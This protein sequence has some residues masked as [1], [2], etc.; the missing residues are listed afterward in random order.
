ANG[1]I[2]W[3]DLVTNTDHQMIDTFQ[4]DS[5]IL[6]LSLENDNEAAQTVDLSSL[7]DNLGDHTS[8]QNIATNGFYISN[9]GEEEGIFVDTT[10]RVGIGTNSPTD[11]LEVP[12][13][14][15]DGSPQRIISNLAEDEVE[16]IEVAWQSYTATINGTLGTISIPS[17]GFTSTFWTVTIYEGEGITGTV[18]GSLSASTNY[19]FSSLNIEQ[20]AN[21]I[22]TFSI[23]ISGGEFDPYSNSDYD[24]G[25][26]SLGTDRDL[27][28]ELFIN[29][30]IE[31]TFSVGENGVLI[32]DY[33]LPLA[34]GTSGQ[35]LQTDG[36][37][38]VNW[39]DQQTDTDNQKIDK[40]NLSG[41]TLEISLE[42]DGESDQTVDLSSIDTDTDNQK[43]DKLNLSGTT[44]EISLEDDG[45]SDQTVDLSS[46]D[47][48]TDNQTIDKLNLNG[49]TL[50]LSLEDDGE[51]DQ[52]VNLASINTDNQT[53]DKFELSGNTL[54]ISLEDDNQ[55]DISVDLTPLIDDLVPVGTIQ[56]WPT[57]TA[58]S[59]WLICNGSSFNAS[60]YPELNSV[61]GGN[62]LPNFNGRF[63]LGAG[64]SGTTGSTSHSIK[65]TGGEEQH[66]LTINEMPAHSHGVTYSDRSKDGN[67]NNVSDLG[68]S[69][70]T[71]TTS[72]TGGSQAHNNMPPFYTINFIIKAE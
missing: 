19:D 36:S 54:L 9:D 12:M 25:I 30:S 63:P 21:G 16:S 26:S 24:G 6:A 68:S 72:S 65:S 18:L 13:G 64:N 17:A 11:Y 71:E 48:D 8:T 10:G 4:L 57:S 43:I 38:N 15:T 41:T 2:L 14:V 69:G 56:M 51:S 20:V 33:G 27:A 7:Q 45:E 61:L 39:A 62:T 52:T 46:I 29:P 3:S 50:E 5:T 60:T 40:L 47:T 59:G 1:V 53:V 44:L 32:N 34:D 35:F 23:L 66:V 22:Y 42:D 28:F 31:G 70:K 55:S 37:G 49:T 67:G 58:P